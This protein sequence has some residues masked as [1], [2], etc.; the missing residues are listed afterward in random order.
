MGHRASA[1]SIQL[2]RCDATA[3]ETEAATSGA[4]LRL[5]V[6]AFVVAIAQ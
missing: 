6:G 5:G 1:A 2:N 3:L 4:P